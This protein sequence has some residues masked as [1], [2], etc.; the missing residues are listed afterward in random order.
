MRHAQGMPARTDEP[1]V[2]KR[3]PGAEGIFIVGVLVVG[4]LALVRPRSPMLVGLLGLAVAMLFGVAAGVWSY[5][6]SRRKRRAVFGKRE[7]IPAEEL[8]ARYY[9]SSGLS[10][11]VVMR[12]WSEC[13]RTLKIPAERLR[14]TDRFDAELSP[15]DFWSSLDDAREDLTKYAITAAKRRGAALDLETIK[16]LDDLIRQLAHIDQAPPV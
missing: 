2:G 9:A 4:V 3:T 16:T 11:D 8:Y 5:L 6:V 15:S 7:A 10:K 12:L 1:A 13:A 14:P